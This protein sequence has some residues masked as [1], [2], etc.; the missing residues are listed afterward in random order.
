M[1]RAFQL[2]QPEVSETQSFSHDEKESLRINKYLTSCG[3]CSRREADRLIQ[4][5]RV[6]IDSQP[7]V[8]GS[9]VLPGQIVS[10]DGQP[11]KKAASHVYIALY[12]PLGIACTLE[13][14]KE[15]N[16]ADF[17]N[18]PER[19]FPIGRLDKDSTGLILL[20]SDGDI[21]NKILRAENNHEKE[22][23]VTVNQP[24][25]PEFLDQMRAGVEITNMKTKQR[26][27]TKPC[28][29]VQSGYKEFRIVLTQGMN[30]QIRRMCTELGYQVFNLKRIRIM[31]IPLGELKP[32]QWRYLTQSELDVLK[33]NL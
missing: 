7:A 15:D 33:Q 5:G 25:T 12:K 30:R 20:T 16:I 21:V 9:Q 23:V 29:V 19:I 1:K 14:D 28:K 27:K 8:I 3:F 11:V 22:Y 13:S 24:V 17:M 4:E 26:V 6:E 2:K 10:V 32:G 18:Y 31:N